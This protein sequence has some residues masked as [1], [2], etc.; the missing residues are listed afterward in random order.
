[1]SIQINQ[2]LVEE[3]LNYLQIIRDT[4]RRGGKLSVADLAED[5]GVPIEKIKNAIYEAEMNKQLS[6]KIPKVNFIQPTIKVH[7][8]TYTGAR[9]VLEAIDV[10]LQKELIVLHFDEKITEFTALF[11]VKITIRRV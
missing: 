5:L 2:K 11:P 9:Q 6:Q 3:G 7:R 4:E 8:N 1:M 10:E